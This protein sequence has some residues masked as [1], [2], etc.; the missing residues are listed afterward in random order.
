MS[1]ANERIGTATVI[2]TVTVVGPGIVNAT[3]IVIAPPPLA[4][5]A[6][7][8]LAVEILNKRSLAHRKTPPRRRLPL[9]TRNLWK[10]L[11][12]RCF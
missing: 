10:K 12:C 4:P 2:G 6:V 9:W 5:T 11:R 7:T 8:L 3:G 1:G